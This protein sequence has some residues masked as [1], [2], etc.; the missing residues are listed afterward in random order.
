MSGH[1]GCNWAQVTYWALWGAAVLLYLAWPLTHLESYAWSNDEG[2]YVQQAALANA[3]YPLYSE[4]LLNKPPLLVW[5]L[6]LAFCLA[7]RTLAVARITSLCLTLLGFIGLG[8][9][10]RQLWGR[11]A[12]LASA[13]LLLGLPEVPVRAHAVMSDLPAMA[14]ALVTLATALAFR[15][16]GRRIWM[17]LSGAALAGTLLIHPLL[18][19]MVLPL[20]A[21][22]FLPG[23]GQTADRPAG[24]PAWL[25]LCV[26]L[27][28]GIGLGLLV[29]AAVDRRAFFTWTLHHNVSTVRTNIEFAGPGKDQMITYL[30]QRWTLV[31]LAVPGSAAL[32]AKSSKRHSLLVVLAWFI[33]TS[34]TLAAWWPVWS[35]YML[36]LAF[37][38]VVAAGGGFAQAGRW[39]VDM[40]EGKSGTRWWR[41]ALATV[42]LVVTVA[43]I[44]ERFGERAP[45]PEG[46]P[47]WSADH[48]AARAFLEEAT[49]SDAF[50]VPYS[51]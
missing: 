29:L 35:H 50:I 24:R 8:A 51:R 21:I 41:I 45:Q 17:A 3:G 48:L 13:A 16:N 12:G 44:V 18:I 31:L 2:L 11:W 30:K 32:L 49:T 28:V 46:G 22:L 5:I 9:V 38:L 26:F 4:V 7:G 15:G 6:Q 10:S 19:Y 27:G 39:V 23:V 47:D 36:F 20:A 34:V 1:P 40:V 43:F 25:D 42:M 33:A 14:F 37:P